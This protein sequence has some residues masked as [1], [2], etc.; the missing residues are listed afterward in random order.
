MTSL[1]LD[2]ALP[3]FLPVFMQAAIGA[4]ADTSAYEDNKIHGDLCKYHARPAMNK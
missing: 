3:A 1:L 4:V 2:L